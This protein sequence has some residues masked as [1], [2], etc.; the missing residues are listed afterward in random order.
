MCKSTNTKRKK[1]QVCVKINV[2]DTM[3]PLYVTAV[4]KSLI[5]LF[6][7]PSYPEATNPKTI[8]LFLVLSGQQQV[9][10]NHA[11][12]LELDLQLRLFIA[13]LMKMNGCFLHSSGAPN[14]K[15]VKGHSNIALLNVFWYLNGRYR[16]ISLP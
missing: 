3:V 9:K 12:V 8:L 13:C 1:N 15:I 7:S 10:L 11:L 6:A 14:E 4:N 5:F 16:H 2:F